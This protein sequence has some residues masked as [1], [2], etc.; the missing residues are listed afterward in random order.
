MTEPTLANTVP[1]S[2]LSWKL[3]LALLLAIIALLLL[4]WQS[5][6]TR[7][8]FRQIEK[9]LGQQLARFDKNN[10]EALTLAKL[11]ENR[12]NESAAQMAQ[13]RQ[14]LADSQNQQ[15]ALQTLYEQL[16]DN[17]E[18]RVVSE[19]EQLLVIANQQLQ[20][21]NNV[22]SALL[23]LQTAQ[24]RLQTLDTAQSHALSTQLDTDVQNLQNLPTVDVA[25]MSEQLEKL[26]S[27]VA[28]LPLV[29][30]RHPSPKKTV[31]SG[32]GSVWASLASEIWQDLHRLIRLERIDRREPPLL[33]PDQTFY[34]R[35]NIKLRLLTARIALLQHD[36]TTYLNDLNT[37]KD[38]LNSHFD[39]RDTLT[40]NALTHIAKLTANSIVVPIPNISA[41]LNLVSKYKLD[42][43]TN[44][45]RKATEKH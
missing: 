13:L 3:S 17:R 36:E 6:S 41:S 40:R 12:S 10:Q 19:V 30:D 29:S 44:A 32:E 21:A 11:A 1:A 18:A 23:A 22:R 16:A 15:E 42:L 7:K 5:A 45:E 14:Q 24:T 8:H 25:E 38:W 20:L 28:N 33:A 9:D 35:E 39:T 34:L 43:E 31:T 2:K 4:V 26:A 37:V 27:D